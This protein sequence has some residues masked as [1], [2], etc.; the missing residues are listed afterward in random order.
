MAE[1]REKTRADGGKVNRVI[2]TKMDG[3]KEGVE[4]RTMP[5]KQEVPECQFMDI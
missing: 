3:R 5:I 2:A 1:E 4:K